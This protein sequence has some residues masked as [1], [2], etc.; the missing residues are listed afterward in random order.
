[1][2]NWS[3]IPPEG[4]RPL[5]QRLARFAAV[6]K[7]CGWPTEVYRDIAFAALLVE[8]LADEEALNG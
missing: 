1:M 6:C 3:D 5:A 2:A 8:H 7:N 4:Y